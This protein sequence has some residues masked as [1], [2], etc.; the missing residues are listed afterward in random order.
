M[1]S[2]DDRAR[3]RP[4]WCGG[5]HQRR[6]HNALAAARD[7]QRIGLSSCHNSP[8][9][10]AQY[11]VSGAWLR[12]RS[13]GER[14]PKLPDHARGRVASFS[15]RS[16]ARLIQQCVKIDRSAQA[17]ALF[18]TLTYPS[19]W[20]PEAAE[21]KRHLDT[22]WKRC[23]RR[24]PR[25]AAIWKLEFQSRGAPHFHLL[26]YGQQFI[27]HAW[28]A[29]QWYETVASG[30]AQHL[31]AGTQVRKVHSYRHAAYYASKYIAKVQQSG[32]GGLY[33]GRYWGVLGRRS[34]PCHLA[35]RRLDKGS[36][37]RLARVLR[38]LVRSRRKQGQHPGQPARWTI[39]NGER[40]GPLMEWATGGLVHHPSF[41]PAAALAWPA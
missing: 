24:Y 29:L 36:F 30:D 34:I 8:R 10:W 31:L 3:R 11:T 22:F 35:E 13:A 1:A 2:A 20:S 9:Y 25:L 32:E 19:S 38:G 12:L 27:P 39:C 14:Q 7:A 26:I 6:D 17:T 4:C 18:V 41:A 37:V 33:V 15:R 5:E 16:R 23:G 28:I 40:A 21:W